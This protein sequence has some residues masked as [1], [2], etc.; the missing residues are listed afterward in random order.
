MQ[1]HYYSV[2]QITRLLAL[3]PKT[4]QRYIREGKLHATKIGKSWR[5]SGHALSRFTEER[6]TQEAA[7]A[8]RPARERVKASAVLDLAAT[9]DEA[10]RIISHL[11][12][13]MQGKPPELGQAS[14][15]GQYNAAEGTVRVTLWG[16][17][18][19]LQCAL[20][21]LQLYMERENAQDVR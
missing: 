14:M 16:S 9:D 2:K 7:S 11:S 6:Q 1:E 12:A 8:Q 4:V 17:L 10:Q 5:V 13:A 18:A 15:A 19:F 3:H 20:D 21:T